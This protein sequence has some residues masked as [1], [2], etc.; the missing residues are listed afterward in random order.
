MWIAPRASRGSR[1][2]G[3][4]R[5]WCV[6]PLT[7]PI[8][9]I[10]DGI[11]RVPGNLCTR[12]GGLRRVRTEREAARIP[13]ALLSG[14][15]IPRRNAAGLHT[16]PTQEDDD[17]RHRPGGACGAARMGHTNDLQRARGGGTAPACYRLHHRAPALPRSRVEAGHRLRADC[18][19]SLR[20]AVAV[21]A[22]CGQGEA[23]RRTT[24]TSR[25]SRAQ[26][27]W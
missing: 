18:D 14:F 12:R 26:W 25:R 2:P 6:A 7:P 5:A 20:R 1:M 16:S 21:A 13:A 23:L 19:V 17:D 15:A 24:S 10:L 4:V 27:S 9:A 11:A 8:A 22:R 3:R